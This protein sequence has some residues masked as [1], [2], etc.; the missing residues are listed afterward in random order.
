MPGPPPRWILVG[1]LVACAAAALGMACGKGPSSVFVPEERA[2]APEAPPAPVVLAAGDIGSCDPAAGTDA[3]ARMLDQL[4]GTILALGDIAYPDGGF[5]SYRDCYH[6]SWGRHRARTRPVPG[7]HDYETPDARQYYAY[8]S[9]AA[10]DPGAGY[11]SFEVGEWLLIALNSEI[12]LGPGSDQLDWLSA[13][14]DSNPRRCAL[15]Y[16]HRPRFSSGRHGDDARL[17][18]AW[19][20]LDGAGVDVVL[21]GHDHHYERFAPQDEDGRLDPDGMRQFVVGTGGAYVLRPGG[22]AANSE[23][24][25]GSA[26]GLLRLELA[27][28]GYAWRFLAASPSGFSDSGRAECR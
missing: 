4:P 3:L 18:A 20:L 26:F 1:P 28:Q 10:G 8:F 11:Y 6:P 17:R 24:R 23:T 21:A 19:A 16:L 14:L 25:D 5:A 13:T 15:A 7:N 2:A 12:G 27:P 22:G 9:T